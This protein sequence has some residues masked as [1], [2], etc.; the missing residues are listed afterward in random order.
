MDCFE[1]GQPRAM[2]GGTAGSEGSNNTRETREEKRAVHFI[3]LME[4]IFSV[5]TGPE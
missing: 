3:V 5:T 1:S 4:V 2:M